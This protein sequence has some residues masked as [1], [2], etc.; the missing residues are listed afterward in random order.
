MT[1]GKTGAPDLIPNDVLTRFLRRQMRCKI[2]LVAVSGAH[3]GGF[4]NR[5]SILEL[6]GIHIEPTENL[7]GLA[8]APKAYNWVGEFEGYRIDYSSQEL[9]PALTQL[10]RGDGSILERILAPR[11]LVD[12]HDLEQVQK[13]SRGVIC[14]RFHSYYRS[15]SRGVQREYESQ[16]PRSVAHVLSAYRTGLTGVHLLRRG[17]LI[18]E[19][20]KLGQLYGFG[21]MHEL[22]HINKNSE[23]AVLDPCSLWIT[24]LAK[25][26]ALV[27]ESVEESPLPV[28]PEHPKPLEDFL[29]DMRRRFFDAMT[30][31]Q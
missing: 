20:Q 10:L 14:R 5:T 29:L 26:H 1:V 17:E 21:N 7:V 8:Q 28:D 15:F 23:N 13:V 3:A 11:Q 6:K 24:R 31:Q 19:L 9:G 27:E 30:V 16:E 2:L 18:Y 12:S 4:A 25:L 22:I